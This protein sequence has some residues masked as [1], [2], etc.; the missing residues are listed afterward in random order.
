MSR[1]IKSGIDKQIKISVA[2]QRLYLLANSQVVKNYLVSTASNGVGE[3]NGSGCTPRGKHKIRLK[4]GYGCD[5]NTVFQGRRPTGEI[6]T[7]EL[8]S[9]FPHR[10]WILSRII[11]LTGIEPGT[12]RGGQVD[13]LKRYIYLHGCPDKEP[14]GNPKSHGCIRMRNQDIIELFELVDNNMPVYISD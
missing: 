11:W 3:L 6:Y 4:I 14:M 9:K 8:A 5:V 7:P 2:E 10:D 12:N 1:L 13:T